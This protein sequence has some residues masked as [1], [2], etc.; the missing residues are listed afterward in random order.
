MERSDKTD[1]YE[2]DMERTSLPKLIAFAVVLF[3]A[4]FLVVGAIGALLRALA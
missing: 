3:L 1:G 2:T 4:A